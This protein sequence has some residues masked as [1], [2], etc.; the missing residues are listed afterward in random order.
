MLAVVGLLLVPTTDVPNAD[1]IPPSLA[2]VDPGEEAD[3]NVT[4]MPTL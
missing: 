2:A 1:A 3:F 4:A